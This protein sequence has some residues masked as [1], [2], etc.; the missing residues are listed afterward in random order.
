MA[1]KK[2]KSSDNRCVDCDVS[3]GEVKSISIS[4]WIGSQNSIMDESQT[5]FNEKF[6]QLFANGQDADIFLNITDYY[7]HDSAHH[8]VSLESG[9]IESGKKVYL[10]GKVKAI[11]DIDEESEDYIP[12][13]N[14][15]PIAQW[16]IS[17]FDCG[18][19]VVIG[20]ESPYCQYNL[21]KPHPTYEEFV[22]K[23]LRK[24]MLAK[25]F[26]EFLERKSD[27]S[28]EEL[29]EYILEK[30]RSFNEKEILDSIQFVLDQIQSYDEAAEEGSEL[31]FESSCLQRVI[32]LCSVKKLKIKSR[33][34]DKQI[35]KKVNNHIGRRDR[36]RVCNSDSYTTH[37][38]LVYTFFDAMFNEVMA[39]KCA[40]NQEIIDKLKNRKLMRSKEVAKNLNSRKANWTGSVQHEDA[41]S[42][43]VYYEAVRLDKETFKIGDFALVRVEKMNGK[44]KCQIGRIISLF[45]DAS[46]RKFAHFNWFIHSTDTLLEEA[47]IP[48]TCYLV[49]ECSDV[50]L[51]EILEKVIINLNESDPSSGGFKCDLIYSEIDGSFEN[52]GSDVQSELDLGKCVGCLKHQR[53]RKQN[54][55]ELHEEQSEG[56]EYQFY[57]S[58]S[59]GE[60]IFRVGS[61]CFVDPSSV[62]VTDYFITKIASLKAPSDIEYDE[63]KYPERY[64]KLT[65]FEN[66]SYEYVKGSLDDCPFPLVVARIMK[67]FKSND[68]CFEDAQIEI[69]LYFRAENVFQDFNTIIEHPIDQ[70]F[71]TDEKRII[72][73]KDLIDLCEVEYYDVNSPS[74][75][76]QPRKFF[77]SSR[78]DTFSQ[79]IVPCTTFQP[80]HSSY[81]DM[82]EVSNFMPLRTLDL[83]AGCGGLSLGF[84][85]SGV[86]QT[87]WA[88]EKD[89][90]SAHSFRTNFPE[91]TVYHEDCNILLKSILDGEKFS[92]DGQ[93]LPKKGDVEMIL[94]GPPCQG[95]S[96]LNRFSDRP[97]STFKN[98]LVITFLSFVDY[99]RPKVVV[100]ENVRDFAQF[101]RGKILKATISCLLSMSYQVKFGV[102]QAGQYGVPQSRR[103]MFIIAT[104]SD[105]S[106]PFLPS[107]S[108]VFSQ[109]CCQLDINIDGKRFSPQFNC[110]R[111]AFRALT[112]ADAISDLP[113][114]V[115]NRIDFISFYK[116]LPITQYQKIMRKSASEVQVQVSLQICRPISELI[117]ARIDR[118]PCS[119]GA[120]WRDLPNVQLTLSGGTIVEKLKYLYDDVK[121]GRSKSGALR[122]VCGCASGKAKD[123]NK[124]QSKQDNTLIPWG[125]VHTANRNYN[126]SGL[127][128]RL[129][130]HGMFITTITKTIPS[131]K[132]GSVIH[133]SEN[134]TVSIR[135]RARSQSFPDSFIFEG[136]LIDIETQI[137][138]AVPPVL[139]RAI[140]LEIKKSL[141]RN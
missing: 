97:Y 102:L 84:D 124:T 44:R 126:W 72:R 24:A 108:H 83:F 132:Q 51:M 130:W 77:C 52:F 58:L 61:D 20:I 15:G 95:F 86:S 7:L 127:F 122:G 3:M 109:R 18:E 1:S 10:I 88:V 100:F 59:R 71:L 111:G 115:G 38:P 49:Q 81:H 123:C 107:P 80:S 92:K 128:G 78:Y 34:S 138:N 67:I 121:H 39:Q 119:P 33:T 136:P 11:Y 26:I 110:Q 104:S 89:N 53:E 66:K 55:I 40:Q 14:I 2:F 116:N 23:T 62:D 91:A 32:Q 106:L 79:K 29:M 28:T 96:S 35:R 12:T 13:Q 45:D 82:D 17:G 48:D 112:V 139:A 69:Q 120:D 19:K 131:S 74:R 37:T 50:S 56:D 9:L 64:R 125:F 68:E 42:R 36:R 60:K 46:G 22:S 31:L 99:Y 73:T 114:T 8:L 113:L 129:Q 65:K 93:P 75:I 137:G 43:R 70:L 101:E 133:P 41:F 141:T 5:L 76:P 54:Q 25:Y 105:T 117:Q 85:Q 6:S 87:R 4:D 94:A 57:Q 135:E 30:D 16:W 134:R 47:G 27:S 90:S 103:R 98:S 63:D 140:G 21:L 118:I